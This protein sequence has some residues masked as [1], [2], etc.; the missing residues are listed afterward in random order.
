M[1]YMLDMSRKIFSDRY[2]VWFL[3]VA[4]ITAI[5]ISGYAQYVGIEFY[6]MSIELSAPF[7]T[8]EKDKK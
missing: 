2:L 5:A 7:K 4:L 1:D 8:A 6:T 3:S